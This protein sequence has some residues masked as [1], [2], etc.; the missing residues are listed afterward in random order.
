[1]L[2]CS[3]RFLEEHSDG[4]ACYGCFRSRCLARLPAAW[5]LMGTR[6]GT[7]PPCIGH[8]VRLASAVCLHPEG[9][10]S[11]GCRPRD[12]VRRLRAALLG[13]GGP[14]VPG[15]AGAYRSRA[16]ARAPAARHHPRRRRWSCAGDSGTRQGGVSSHRGRQSPVERCPLSRLGG[17]RPVQVRGRRPSGVAPPGR[18]RST[19]WCVCGCC[20]TASTGPASSGS[21]A[22]WH[23]ARW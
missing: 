7:G 23:A 18:R 19:R 1:M 5:N 21:C 16:I 12:R 14:M 2:A 3:A 10:P 15:N 8:G 11:R 20:H 22:G 13:R 9:P 4:P 17:L 6:G